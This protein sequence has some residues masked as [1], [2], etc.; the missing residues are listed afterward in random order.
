MSIDNNHLENFIQLRNR[1]IA[2]RH[3][4]SEANIAHLISSDPMTGIDRHGL[5]PYGRKQVE[6]NTKIFLRN[7]DPSEKNYMIISSDFRR[8]RETAEIL[9]SNL[10]NTPSIQ[11]DSRLRERYFGIYDNT[12][13]ENYPLIWKN[14]EENGENDQVEPVEKVRERTTALIVELEEKYPQQ[15]IFLVSHGDSLQIL[16]TAFERFPQANKQRY[17]PHIE[18]AEFRELSLK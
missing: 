6:E 5:S 13:D 18:R 7:N 9:A 12:S 14:D 15:V 16:Q 11:F 1:Y 4:E 3:G 8:A 10:P 2:V 17:L